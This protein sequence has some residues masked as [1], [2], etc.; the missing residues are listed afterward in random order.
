MPR[1]TPPPWPQRRGRG[2]GRRRRRCS[3]SP[4]QHVL[5]YPDGELD[6][7]ARS[8]VASSWGGSARLRPAT[9]LCPDPT[10]V[11]FGEDYYNH[12]DHRAIGFAVLDALAPGGRAAALLPRRG[13]GPPGRDG[14]AVGHPRADRV[15]RRHGDDRRQGGRRGLPREPVR[16]RRRN[17]R[18]R[19][20]ARAPRRTAGAPGWPSPKASA[21]SGSVADRG[22]GRRAAGVDV[23]CTVLHVDMDAFFAAG[24]GPRRPVPRRARR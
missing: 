9:V 4:S 12:R 22:A 24:R 13:P 19:R 15:G 2:D 23:G 5:G 21:G 20:C 11:F 1:S 7:H 18:P 17:G 8:C 10:A 14:A 3:G 16:R 6:E